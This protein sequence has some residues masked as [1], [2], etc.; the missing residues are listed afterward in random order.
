ME[1][2]IEKLEEI[3]AYGTIATENSDHSPLAR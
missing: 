2:E 1:A 3:L